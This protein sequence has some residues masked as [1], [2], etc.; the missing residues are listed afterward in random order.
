MKSASDTFSLDNFIKEALKNPEPDLQPFDWSE[1]T[2]LLRHEQ[3]SISILENKRLILISGITAAFIVVSFGVFELI[4]Y[5]TSLPDS[6]EKIAAPI[7][8]PIK[9]ITDSSASVIKTAKIGSA[10]VD[11]DTSSEVSIL[12]PDTAQV[13]KIAPVVK[14]VQKQEKKKKQDSVLSIT[15]T[16]VEK[17]PVEELPTVDTSSKQPVQEIKNEAPSDIDTTHK[18]FSL[19]PKK[20]KNKK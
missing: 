7:L 14:L 6:T 17:V 16:P 20:S 1:I 8:N 15:E 13:K 3:K 2:V 19:W 18:K 9:K 4:Q 11:D 10:F 5:Y 12:E